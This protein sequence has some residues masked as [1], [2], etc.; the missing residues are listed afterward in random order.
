MK[1]TITEYNFIDAFITMNRGSQFTYEAKAALYEYYTGMEEETGTEIELDI[2]AIC[3]EMSEYE[4][5]E[6][7]NNDYDVVESVEDIENLTTVIYILD[8]NGNRRDNFIILN[9]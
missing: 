8:T 2:I 3:C 9:Y 6:A 1:T 5:L 7:Y 4:N